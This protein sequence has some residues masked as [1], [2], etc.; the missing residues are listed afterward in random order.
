VDGISE[1]ESKHQIQSDTDSEVLQSD[2]SA[3]VEEDKK[4]FEK[5]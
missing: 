5:H 3:S 4:P 1:E 2:P